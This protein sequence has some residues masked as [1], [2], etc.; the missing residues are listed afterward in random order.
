MTWVGRCL[1]RAEAY[2]KAQRGELADFRNA[3]VDAGARPDHNVV[4][5]LDRL[6]GLYFWIVAALQEVR[7][8]MMIRDGLRAP[9]GA[10]KFASGADLVAAA[11]A[12]S[13]R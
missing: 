3:M 7:W 2:L 4:D 11:L 13:R 9:P 8:H 1:E 6:D 5:A 10:R 12:G